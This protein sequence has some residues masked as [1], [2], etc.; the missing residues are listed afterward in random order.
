MTPDGGRPFSSAPGPR[1]LPFFGSLLEMRK[2][3][4]GFYVRAAQEHGDYVRV[5][6][7]PI[8]VLLVTR[9]EDVKYVLQDNSKNYTKKGLGYDQLRAFLGGGLIFN[10]GGDFW[11]KQRKLTQPAFHMESLRYFVDHFNRS[12]SLMID[13]WKKVEASGETISILPEMMKVTLQ[14]IGQTLLSRDLLDDAH[15]VG[16]A[17]SV[18]LE[19]AEIRIQSVTPIRNFLPTRTNLRVRRARRVL[20][21]LVCDIIGQR[22]QSK[23]DSRRDLLAMYMSAIDE[24]T[25]T[26]M[27]DEQVHDEIMSIFIAGHET[28]ANALSWLWYLLSLNPEVEAKIRVELDQVLA[29]RPPELGD[30]EKLRY[31]EMAFLEALRLYPPVWMMPRRSVEAD[32]IG[33]YR[34]SKGTTVFVSPYLTQR[35]PRCW[36]DPTAFK[37]ERFAQESGARGAGKYEFFAFA[38]GPRVCIGQRFAIMEAVAIIARVLQSFEFVRVSNLPVEPAPAITLRPGAPIRFSLKCRF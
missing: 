22:R 3:S 24:D 27:T 20:R 2:D 8:P 13:R 6:F 23:S 5:A 14:V 10:E 17:L 12:S 33:E 1:G 32:Q 36:S 37:P 34:I 19:E 15:G 7:G 26:G 25:G 31:T 11:R 29:G 28:T 21:T 38:G 18:I 9:P 35:D 4:V 30:F 16:A